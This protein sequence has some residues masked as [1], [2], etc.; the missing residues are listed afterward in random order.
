MICT[1][2]AKFM[3]WF[4]LTKNLLGEGSYSKVYNIIEKTSKREFALKVINAKNPLQ[5]SEAFNEILVVF[6][7]DHASIVNI[8]LYFIDIS[9]DGEFQLNLIMEKGKRNLLKEINGRIESKIKK[10]FSKDEIYELIYCMIKTF[11]YLQKMNI[12]HR[13]I[14]PENILIFDDFKYKITDFGLSTYNRNHIGNYYAGTLDYA[15]PKL[16][17]YY[18]KKLQRFQFD[19][20]KADVFSLGFKMNLKNM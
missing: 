16:K 3:S 14:K 20:Y 19:I 18:V 5:L 17:K 10:Y 15:E 7:A 11:S 9:K 6:R 12:A 8:I 13:D 4:T 1:S 2:K